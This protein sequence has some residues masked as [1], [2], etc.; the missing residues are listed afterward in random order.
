MYLPSAD[1]GDV[2]QWL[3]HPLL[4]APPPRRRLGLVEQPEQT[5]A[6]LAPSLISV[7]S[8]FAARFYWEKYLASMADGTR[9]RAGTTNSASA[10]SAQ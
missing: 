4:Q 8:C 1:G 10:I 5:E 3:E 6:L 7:E 9:R 2:V